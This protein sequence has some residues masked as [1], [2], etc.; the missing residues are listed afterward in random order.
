MLIMEGCLYSFAIFL[1]TIF[2]GNIVWYVLVKIIK[3]RINY[4]KFQY[5]IAPLI[6]SIVL[7]FII[8]IVVP[9]IIERK[10]HKEFLTDRLKLYTD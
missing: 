2:L 1:Q 10:A 6:I 3:N 5:P 9:L 8:C 7:L 4:F